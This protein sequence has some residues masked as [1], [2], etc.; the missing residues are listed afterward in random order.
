MLTDYTRSYGYRLY[1]DNIP[2]SQSVYVSDTSTVYMRE[3]IRVLPTE[4]EPKTFWLLV[5]MLYH[6]ATGDSWELRPFLH[7]ARIGMSMGAN[8]RTFVRSPPRFASL[9]VPYKLRC[10]FTD[11]RVNIVPRVSPLPSFSLQGGRGG[12][13]P[14]EQGYSPVCLPLS[15]LLTSSF[16]SPWYLQS[17]EWHRRQPV[18]SKTQ[19][20]FSWRG[21]LQ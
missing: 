13:R 10:L 5:R 20:A 7:T 1:R 12:E 19:D 16:P 18:H 2:M 14:W 15:W 6:W 3:N 4:V 21:N 11:S 8:E 9:V 17:S